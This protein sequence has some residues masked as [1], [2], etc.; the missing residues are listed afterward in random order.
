[1]TL[2]RPHFLV[3]GPAKTG[4][5]WLYEQLR[6]VD[7]FKMPPTKEVC[8][9]NEVNFKHTIDPANAWLLEKYGVTTQEISAESVAAAK[10]RF[11]NRR[12]LNM[13]F[14]FEQKQYLWGLFYRYFPRNTGLLSSYFYSLLFDNREGITTG[15]ISPLYFPIKEEVI[16]IIARR[17]PELKVVFIIREPVERAWSNIR[18]NYYSALAVPGFSIEGYL[19]K[20]NRGGDYEYAFTNWEKHFSANRIQYLFYDD[21]ANQ[22]RKFLQ[23]FLDFVRPG[24]QI[25]ALF[26]EKIGKGVEKQMDEA[27]RSE[28]IKKNLPQYHFLAK[29]F[30]PGS[31]PEKWLTDVLNEVDGWK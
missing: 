18:M 10:K 26:E 7:G 25:N 22:P 27:L 4:T 2:N 15:D 31:Y 9:F 24:T 20:P 17:F 8:F 11:A 5:T 16:E 29:K 23:Q 28:L 1:M 19:A 30:G 21:L 3:V 13:Q 14:A 12:K 6:H